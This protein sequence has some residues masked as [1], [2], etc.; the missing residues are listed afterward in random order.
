MEKR[1][2]TRNGFQYVGP[3]WT[4]L[5]DI[6]KEIELSGVLKKGHKIRLEKVTQERE[7]KGLRGAA[8]KQ[9][10]F[11][12]QVFRID[13]DFHTL[14]SIA[15]TQSQ[16]DSTRLEI[17]R[18]LIKK[19]RENRDDATIMRPSMRLLFAKFR[20][21]QATRQESIQHLASADD[22]WYEYKH[23]EP[24]GTSIVFGDYLADKI[25]STGLKDKRAVTMRLPN[26][27]LSRD[28]FMSVE[29]RNESVKELAMALFKVELHRTADALH[30]VHQGGVQQT[31]HDSK[32][33]LSRVLE[34]DV[35]AVF[36]LDVLDAI[37]ASHIRATER[38][39]G[40]TRTECVKMTFSKGTGTINVIMGTMEGLQ[41]Q[42]KLGGTAA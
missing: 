17:I 42:R 19:I 2:R 15:F 7:N 37:S 31:I 3:A 21:S 29:V 39:E 20:A 22:I 30:V 41:I 34:E 6:A 35:V 16:I 14:C 28:C 9:H 27:P 8:L 38:T 18:E 5:L 33:A 25:Q 32:D 36:G 23:A 26:W 12:E 10:K 4:Q 13:S 40:I 24:A 1:Q 11:L